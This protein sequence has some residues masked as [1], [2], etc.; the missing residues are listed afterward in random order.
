MSIYRN[1]EF[2]FEFEYL[3]NNWEEREIKGENSGVELSDKR[4][5]RGDSQIIVRGW[6]NSQWF[7][8]YL[9]M[10][11]GTMRWIEHPQYGKCLE[12]CFKQ[13]DFV[14]SFILKGGMDR[15]LVEEFRA[16]VG[17]YEKVK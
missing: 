2:G 1:R 8:D 12:A 15:A 10:E 17:T 5:L 9:I 11:V 16:M 7:D 13:K 4:G 6:F 3:G 14:I